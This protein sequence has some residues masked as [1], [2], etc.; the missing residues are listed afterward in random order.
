M[1][2]SSGAFSIA[3]LVFILTAPASAQ[4]ATQGDIEILNRKIMDLDFR[5][6][7][8]E[9]EKE[10]KRQAEQQAEKQASER[11]RMGDVAQLPGLS[12]E[13]CRCAAG[14]PRNA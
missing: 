2:S 6:R 1:V 14:Q 12:A 13:N 7:T 8:L 11:R 9:G 5:L 4:V 3:V 10:A